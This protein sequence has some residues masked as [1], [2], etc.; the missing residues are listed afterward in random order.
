MRKA[1]GFFFFFSFCF[2]FFSFKLLFCRLFILKLHAGSGVA[3]HGPGST[4]RF[5]S[6]LNA[7]FFFFLVFLFVLFCFSS[8]MRLGKIQ[9]SQKR[10]CQTV[11]GKGKTKTVSYPTVIESSPQSCLH[12]KPC[13]SSLICWS[14]CLGSLHLAFVCCFSFFLVSI[15]VGLS[16]LSVS[17]TSVRTTEAPT[18]EMLLASETEC[19]VTQ[20]RAV[21]PY[22]C[23][24]YFG[25]YHPVALDSRTI[26]NLT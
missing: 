3:S 14:S 21:L 15:Y 7:N 18:C 16:W 5:P 13:T 8:Q 6:Q 11:F 23:Q 17:Q 19:E 25:V 22:R 26:K 20:R 1:S 9:Q 10:T 12:G 4:L 2:L 24:Q